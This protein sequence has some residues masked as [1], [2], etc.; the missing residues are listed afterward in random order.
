MK[1]N[2]HIHSLT[3]TH[4][5]N[6]NI[7]KKSVQRMKALF[8]HFDMLLLRWNGMDEFST[9]THS[10]RIQSSFR[11]LCAVNVAYVCCAAESEVVKMKK[12]ETSIFQQNRV[13]RI[14]RTL[15]YVCM[16]HYAL[17]YQPT[18]Q[19]VNQPTHNRYCCCVIILFNVCNVHI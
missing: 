12:S 1:Y 10:N 4:T 6:S 11:C 16:L 8:W 5:D 3:H 13:H 18:N 19:P 14:W 7:N 15:A 2:P 17:A 9:V